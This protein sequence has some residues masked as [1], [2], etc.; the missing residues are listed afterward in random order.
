M[1]NRQK[2]K[3]LEVL[4]NFI[5]RIYEKGFRFQSIKS[6]LQMLIDYRFQEV[7]S[8]EHYDFLNE[9]LKSIG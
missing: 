3:V 4:I 7:V 6:H 5:M 8:D 9:I 2:E 1:E